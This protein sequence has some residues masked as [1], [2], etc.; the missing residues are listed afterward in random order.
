MSDT[1][2]YQVL[3]LSRNASADEIKRA[4]RKLAKQYHPDRNKGDTGAEE[5]FKEVQHAYSVLKDK[6]KRAQYDQFGEVG[7]GD[8]RR[9]PNGQ[10]VYT[11]GT[12]GSQVNVE[13]LE[14]LFGA[15]GGGGRGQQANP[16]ERL[17]RNAG[18]GRG[19]RQHAQP[20]TR[21]QDVERR[22]SLAF[23]QAVRGASVEVD[24]P[25]H[26]GRRG[27]HQTLKVTIPAGVEDGQRIRLKGKGIP[28]AG[29]G[30]PGD[31][32]LICSIR[33]HAHF[34][35]VGKDIH[36]DTP[37]SIT[38][39]VLGTKIEVPTLDGFVTLTSPPGTSGG[40]KLRLKQRGV[41][42]RGARSAGDQYVIVRIAA[43]AS[44]DDEQKK[45]VEQLAETLDDNPREG[46]G[47]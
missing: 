11:W 35:R 7:A 27:A 17:F 32:Y 46:V 1:N 16:F 23:E 45:L 30:P 36:L 18:F 42:G 34:R 8:F 39:A 19:S 5:K 44:L 12:S 3:G 26:T 38:E 6:D 20:P 24:V 41:P 21:G 29:G 15:F 31:L 22:V 43:P 47:W 14:S 33:A 9:T 4:Y 37:I 13:D 25:N 28:G 10:D 40:S 2:L